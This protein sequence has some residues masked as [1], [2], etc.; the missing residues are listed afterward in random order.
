M[1]EWIDK[2]GK[3]VSRSIDSKSF[4]NPQKNLRYSGPGYYYSFYGTDNFAINLK[5][6]KPTEATETAEFYL[7]IIIV[8]KDF[9]NYTEEDIRQKGYHHFFALGSQD[10]KIQLMG[11]F[12]R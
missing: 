12:T 4:K 6:N 2:D 3:I 1:C 5:G 9:F 10:A 8:Q 11:L 7:K